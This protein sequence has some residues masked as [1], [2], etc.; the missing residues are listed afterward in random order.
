MDRYFAQCKVGFPCATV[1]K[2]LGNTGD[3]RNIGLIPGLRRSPGE[4]SGNPFQCSCLENSWRE[5]P[6]GYS[7]WS[8]KELDTTQHTH[9]RTQ[10]KVLQRMSKGIRYFSAFTKLYIE[11]VGKQVIFYKC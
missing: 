7:P 11:I 10:C 5:E 8:L 9:T 3:K 1:V 2:N 4:G 6:G